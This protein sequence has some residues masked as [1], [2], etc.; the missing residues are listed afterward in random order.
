MNVRDRVA[1][2][3]GASSG[4]GLATARLL[5]AKGARVALAARSKDT[6][7][8]ISQEIP[9]SLPVPCDVTDPA[10]VTAMVRLAEER[11]GRIDILVNS[12][13]QG[14]DATIEE[15][16]LAQFQRLFDLYLAGPLVA[17]QAVIPA[18]RRRGEGAIVNIAS[19]SALMHLPGMGAY[20]AVKAALA[21]LSLT[22]RE[23]LKDDGITVSVVYPYVTLTNFDRNTITEGGGGEEPVGEQPGGSFDYLPHPPDTPEFLAGKIVEGIERGAAEIIPH[24]WMKPEA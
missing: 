20:A 17:M 2:V 14:Y 3:T 18:M 21:H 13:G 12:A 23:E 5:S 7:D 10:Q 11:F 16:D 19:G 15:T 9:G 22:A 1:L 6:L 8:A 24:E 4:I